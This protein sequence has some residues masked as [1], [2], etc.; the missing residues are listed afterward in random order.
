MS[1]ENNKPNAVP[2]KL[3]AEAYTQYD[4]V[5]IVTA[6]LKDTM[7][8][9][10][11]EAGY[12]KRDFTVVKNIINYKAILEKAGQELKF[13]ETT[14]TDISPDELKKM[15]DSDDT[16]IINIGR[17]SYEKGQL[18]LID[19]F[20]SAASDDPKARL[21][22]LGSYGPMYPEILARVEKSPI[23]NRITVIKFMSNP[24]PLLK[25]CDYFVLSSLY[26]G[27]GL[28]LCEADILGVPCF[29]PKI[30]GPTGFMEKYGGMLVENSTEGIAD[31]IR[32]CLDGKVKKTL[33]V[34]YAEYNREAVEEFEDMVERLLKRR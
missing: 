6:E 7:E 28:V 12:K 29:S 33:T 18:R 9:Y 20:E 3:L 14:E 34:D 10:I 16:L 19:A 27:F 26:E 22:I 31:G 5:A 15:L 1:G 21:I 30:T 23:R 2:K 25:R 17:F 32:A 13:D 11:E 4:E 8:R 24:Y